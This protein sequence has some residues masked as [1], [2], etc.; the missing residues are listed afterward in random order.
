[1][2]PV[3]ALFRVNALFRVTEFPVVAENSCITLLTA[4]IDDDKLV[5]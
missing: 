4:E 2:T 1:M 3:A 5:V